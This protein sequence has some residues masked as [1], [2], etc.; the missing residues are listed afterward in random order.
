[1]KTLIVI[2]GCL[3]IGLIQADRGIAQE[4]REVHR[5][6][7][8]NKDGQVF[9]DTYKG[10]IT[11]TT[12]DKPQVDVH[13]TIEADGWGKYEEEKVEDTEIRFRTSPERVE[14]KTDYDE[15]DH[16]GFS[17]FRI[18]SGHDGTMPFVHYNI[19][20]PATA[21]LKI[22]DYKSDS[23]IQDITSSIKMET[24]KG[25]VVIENVEG[26][27][28]IETYKGDVTIDFS[29]YSDECRF[30]TYKGK[31]D[32]TLPKDAGFK[33]DADLGRRAD[34]DCDFDLNIKRKSRRDDYYRATVNGGGP[35]LSIDTDKGD[36][37]IRQK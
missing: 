28:D 35:I 5:T 20:M 17:F 15:I 14:I 25:T 27:V 16:H 37:R 22:K 4:S 24:Y 12:W 33:L 23:K 18:F 10:S 8:L 32:L 34:F 36:I 1:M 29:R 6:V 13:A 2:F 9:I 30:E 31:I 7:D 21:K 26:P 11:I 19:M 3:L